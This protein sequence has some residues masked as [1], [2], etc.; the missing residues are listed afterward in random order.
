M[1]VLFLGSKSGTSVHRARALERLGH[2]ILHIDPNDWL[3]RSRLVDVWHWRT[4]GLFLERLVAHRTMFELGSR[5]FDL[6]WVDAGDLVGPTLLRSLR[7]QS[8]WIVNYNVDDPFGKRDHLRWRLYLKSVPQYDMVVV[9]RDENILEAK[10]LGARRVHHTYRTADEIAH[11]PRLITEEDR[12]R[13]SSEVLFVGTWFPERGPFIE[14]LLDR[15][16][17]I[18]LYGGRWERDPHWDRLK[19]AWRGPAL[20]NEDDYAKAIQTAKIC[21]GLVS[22][23]NR[24]LHTQRS[25]EIPNAGGLLCAKRTVDHLRMYRD[26]EEAIF[27]DSVDECASTC[28]SLLLDDE[29]RARIAAN[30]QNRCLTSNYRNE[31]MIQ[32][33]LAE[34]RDSSP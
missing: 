28:R 5:Q 24:D 14:G 6:T 27:W 34:L 8:K 3:P 30:G 23:G 17:P 21:V 2:S 19:S 20:A 25:A 11:A 10:Q 33:I 31:A 22:E 15:A 32:N 13:W 16:I 1:R 12:K 4:G 29:R 26:G 7:R 18:T 9:V